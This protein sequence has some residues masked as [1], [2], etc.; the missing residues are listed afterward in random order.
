MSNLYDRILK[1]NIV[2]LLPKL[3]K[4]LLGIEIVK[5]EELKDKIQRTNEREADFLR[6]VITKTGEELI[7]HLE[8]QASDDATMLKRMQLYH[9]LITHK[10]PLPIRQYVIYIANT[11][12]KMRT[13]LNKE[14]VFTGFE[15]IDLRHIAYQDLLESDIPEEVVLAILG[16]FQEENQEAVLQKILKRLDKLSDTPNTLNKYIHHLLTFARLRNL[17][18]ITEK[19]LETMGIVYD[20]EKDAF[21]K[22]GEARGFEKGKNEKTRRVVINLFKINKLS[23]EEIAKISELSLEEVNKIIKELQ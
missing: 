11:L 16:D 22:K 23:V 13:Q 19:Q 10:Y 1:E 21:F 8:F 20:I 5:S 12:P 18:D 14:E 6:K 7:I 2:T 3:S 17:T 15:L 9:A 4:K